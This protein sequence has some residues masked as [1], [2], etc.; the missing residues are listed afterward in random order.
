MMQDIEDEFDEID[1]ILKD[2]ESMKIADNPTNYEEH[3]EHSSDD[4]NIKASINA[5]EL[6]RKFELKNKKKINA[7]TD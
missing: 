3:I 4:E 1:S 6:L 2:V 5:Q 7:P